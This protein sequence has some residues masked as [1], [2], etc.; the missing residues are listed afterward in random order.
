MHA[1]LVAGWDSLVCSTNHHITA[2][3]STTVLKQIG[4]GL[5]LKPV[6]FDLR[7]IIKDTPN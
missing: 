5:R 1:G 6:H 7:R 4:E 2:G 3:V